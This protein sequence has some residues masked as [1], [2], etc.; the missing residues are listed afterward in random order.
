[1]AQDLSKEPRSEIAK[2]DTRR[3]A[4]TTSNIISVAVLGN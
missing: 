1:M 3:R 2:L 4:M